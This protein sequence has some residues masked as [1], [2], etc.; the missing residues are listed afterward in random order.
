MTDD[1]KAQLYNPYAQNTAMNLLEKLSTDVQQVLGHKVTYFVTDPDKKGQD[2]TLFEYSLYNVVCQSDIKVSVVD[3]NFPDSQIIMNQFDLN[4]FE[5]MEVHIT[6]QQF[7]D[8]FGPQ[9]RPSKED[10][11][12]FCNLNRMFQVD[13][14]Q[15]FRSFNNSAVYYKLILKK[16]TQ[17]ANVQAGSIDIKNKL[18]ELTKN[19]TI[20]EL[21][22]AEQTKD[23]LSIANKDQLKP[24][25]REPIRLEYTAGIDKELIENS[26]N[27]ISKSHYNLSTVSYRNSAVRYKNLNPVFTPANNVGFMAWFSINNYIPNE[28]YNLFH[29]YNE[30]NRTGWK[31]E[32]KNDSIYLTMNSFTYSFNLSGTPAN[33]AL[34]ENTWYCYVLNID[35]RNRNV[36]Q[37]I[38]KRNVE[39]ED[40]AGSLS[41][42]ILKKVYQNS[43]D[44]S[45]ISF[46][47]NTGPQIL[48]SDMKITNI[49]YFIDTIPEDYHNKIL[50]Q[51]IIGDDS[52]Y[53]VFADNATTRIYL[54]KYPLFE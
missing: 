47:S 37:F 27:I 28:I 50:N 53:L 14:A 45:P 17:K 32:L 10:F 29:F 4:L 31:S 41:N 30:T 8:T 22:G 6:K 36:E 26:L 38:Y 13:H 9:R 23:K 44:M 18:S 51:Y 21:L 39:D 5:S 2:H 54:P 20:D 15:Q 19:T 35:Q 42:T 43:Q 7:K 49:R 1:E 48:A 24:L 46:Q 33:D 52:K 3:N 11:L 12:Y 25:T 34:V 16:Y 40:E